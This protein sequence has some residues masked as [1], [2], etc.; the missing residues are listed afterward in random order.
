MLK[1]KLLYCPK[2]QGFHNVC[3]LAPCKCLHVPVEL[4]SNLIFAR[5][6]NP[7]TQDEQQ[8]SCQTF[9]KI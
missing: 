4:P 3:G 9:A 5:P 8:A 2:K 6:I 1:V 7:Y